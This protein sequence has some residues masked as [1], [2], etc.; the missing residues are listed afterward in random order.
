MSARDKANRVLIHV[1]LILVSITMLV[2][3]LWM[4]LTAFWELVIKT[5]LD[6]SV[7]SFQR[8]CLKFFL[9]SLF[10]AS[11]AGWAARS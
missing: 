4:I 9:F 6:I 11:A 5:L 10:S 8:V 1:I 3:F 7:H 2:P